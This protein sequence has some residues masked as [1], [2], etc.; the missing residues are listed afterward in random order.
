MVIKVTGDTHGEKERIKEY[1]ELYDSN[2]CFDV[3]LIC[4]DFGY[5]F[6]DNKKERKFLDIIENQC[7]FE[8]WFVDGNHENFDSIYKYPIEN[9]NGGKI[10]RIKKNIIH[11]IRGEVYKINNKKLF[12]FG[13]GYSIDKQ[14][15]QKYEMKNNRKVWWEQEFPTQEEIDNAYTNL[16]KNNWNVDYVFTHS[17]PTNVLPLVQE[18]FI[19]DAKW[20]VDIVNKTLEDIRQKLN[21]K[22]WYFGHY[23][24]EKNIDEDFTV[25]YLTS[26]TIEI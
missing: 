12:V 16:G 2:P 11:L 24:G 7:P 25:L 15:R 4:G 17:A 6:R 10:H 3:L 1:K 9:W 23:H 13:G 21:F 26:R 20:E 19:S 18:F 8:I 14:S 5:I 22:H